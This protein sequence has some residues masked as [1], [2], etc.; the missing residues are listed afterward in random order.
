MFSLE[1][2]CRTA[3]LQVDGLARSY[4]PQKLRIYA[5]G[6]SSGRPTSRRSTIPRED[7][8]WAAEWR[9]S[10]PRSRR[11]TPAAGDLDSAR[12]AWSVVEDAYAQRLR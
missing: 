5:C 11:A 4:G 6:P 12:Y 2:Y 9:T 8:S 1:V 10:A 7:V 3:K